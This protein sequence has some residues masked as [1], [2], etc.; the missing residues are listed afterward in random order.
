[1]PELR[2]G[3]GD[4]V[5]EDNNTDVKYEGEVVHMEGGGYS[6]PSRVLGLEGLDMIVDAERRERCFTGRVS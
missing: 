5:L 3:L 2:K 4:R 1:M 6:A